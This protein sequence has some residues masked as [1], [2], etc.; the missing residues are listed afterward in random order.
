MFY[1]YLITIFLGILVLA[2]ILPFFLKR[3]REGKINY[4]AGYSSASYA[5]MLS[6]TIN[7]VIKLKYAKYKF[8]RRKRKRF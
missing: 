5:S 3:K 1:D 4:R 8:R 7:A 6:R 2:F